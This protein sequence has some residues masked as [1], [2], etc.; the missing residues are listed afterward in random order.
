MTNELMRQHIVACAQSVRKDFKLTMPKDE[1]LIDI[2]TSLPYVGINLPGGEEY[3]FQEQEAS[4][5]LE[6][7]EKTAE[8][9]D[10]TTEEAL[11][12]MSQG[13]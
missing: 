6:E 12:W 11:I 10:V 13:W 4:E 7:A 1:K 8:T 5:L 2:N 3:F 9:F